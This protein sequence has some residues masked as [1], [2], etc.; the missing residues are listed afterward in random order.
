MQNKE[1]EILN[2]IIIT[3]IKD[4]DYNINI[5]MNKQSSKVELR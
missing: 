1:I 3:K 4:L 5:F 2:I